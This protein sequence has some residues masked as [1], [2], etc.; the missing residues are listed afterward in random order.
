MEES[1]YFRQCSGKDTGCTTSEMENMKGCD[2][3]V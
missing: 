3:G 1:E 2:D